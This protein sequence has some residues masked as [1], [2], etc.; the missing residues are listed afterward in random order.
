MSRTSLAVAACLLQ[1]LTLTSTP[2]A[3][4]QQV[5]TFRPG[6]G[7]RAGMRIQ[8]SET[9]VGILREGAASDSGRVST[10][11][12]TI[13]VSDHREGLLITH[14]DVRVERAGDFP[15]D[16]PTIARVNEV[17]ADNLEYWMRLPNIVVTEEGE[18]LR[19]E[20]LEA[21]RFTVESS[22]R[23]VASA[24]AAGDPEIL[25]LLD[26]MLGAV[27][28][29]ET[30]EAL[31]ADRWSSLVEKWAFTEWEVGR[32][33]G[34]EIEAPNPLVPGPAIEYS[35][36]A[37]VTEKI[38][39][40]APSGGVMCAVFVMVTRPADAALAVAARVLADSLGVQLLAAAGPEAPEEYRQG[41]VP[42]LT[43]EELIVEGR[44]ELMTDPVSLL[45]LWLEER[46]RRSGRGTG[47]GEPFG[48]YTEEIL[49]TEFSYAEGR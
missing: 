26:E 1:S 11:T 2:P 8:A 29:D 40:A 3:L 16:L 33:L 34:A 20:D 42:P 17:V 36:Q 28:S 13:T 25:A 7:W 48:F 22:I 32:V 21:F 30:I 35:I 45:P 14:E 4:A 41:T 19:V 27:V 31:A 6:F 37:G 38:E 10:A 49:T 12:Y 5:E 44:I 47:L 23:P 18:F 46:Q 15:A 43:F 9:R 39:C 24:M